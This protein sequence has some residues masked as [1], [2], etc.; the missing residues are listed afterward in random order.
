VVA[1]LEAQAA[2]PDPLFVGV[3]LESRNET[4]FWL[5]AVHVILM[6]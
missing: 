3:R 5:L 6:T 2:S 4:M 1:P